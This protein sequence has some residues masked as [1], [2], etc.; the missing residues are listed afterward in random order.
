MIPHSKVRQNAVP[1]PINLYTRIILKSIAINTQV[2]IDCI[3]AMRKYDKINKQSHGHKN[4]VH[5]CSKGN[6]RQEKT[7]SQNIYFISQF[8]RR[9]NASARSLPQNVE[10]QMSKTSKITD[11]CCFLL[12]CPT[13][14]CFQSSFYR[15][16][17][18]FLRGRFILSSFC[19]R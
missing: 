13:S 11:L 2:C 5:S 7:F 4:S 14:V 12:Y 9:G 6:I 8:A 17:F 16:S 1:E 10:M 3:L 19:G 15:N 18:K